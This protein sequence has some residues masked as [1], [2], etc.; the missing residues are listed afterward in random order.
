VFG[1]L[2]FLSSEKVYEKDI[3]EPVVE[4]TI[5]RSTVESGVVTST[6]TSD[7]SVIGG[8]PETYID[9]I[10][11][12]FAKSTDVTLFK[13][14]RSLGDVL[15]KDAVLYTYKGKDYKVK[16]A[17][18]IVDITASGN[19]IKF[20]LLNYDKLFITTS[21]NL[22]TLSMLR[23]N[24]KTTLTA[25]VGGADKDFGGQIQNFGYEVTDGK[26]D[27]F[28]NAKK[29]LLPGTPVKVHFDIVH[30]A[31]SIY[32]LRQMLM[33]DGDTY[34]VE[35]EEDGGTRMRRDVKIGDFFNLYNDGVPVE[36][37]V[38]TEGLSQGEKL[39]VDIME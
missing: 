13:L 33:K 5:L 2:Y 23:Y 38:I 10:S 12:T 32:I 14:H 25:K 3:I 4:K 11:V 18:K 24:T 8:S 27:V 34:Y 17:C 7:G 1:L 19:T 39:I 26:V 30:D 6:F 9:T 21:V 31:E 15:K 35:V 20:A 28:I 22:D 36:C 16:S 29:K 37:V